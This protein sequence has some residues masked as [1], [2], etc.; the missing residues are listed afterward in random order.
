MANI[1]SQLWQWIQYVP[2]KN[3]TTS[4]GLN[5]IFILHLGHVSTLLFV[6]VINT[7]PKTS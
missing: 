2:L 3:N 7:M 1:Y 4:E 6:A 5:E